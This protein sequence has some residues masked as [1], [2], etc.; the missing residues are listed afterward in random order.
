MSSESILIV[1]D[2]GLIALHLAEFLEQAGYH[3]AGTPF[4]GE[5]CVQMVRHSPPDLI[6][7]DIALAGPM[8]GVEAARQIRHRYDIPVIFLSAYSDQS[9]IDEA[10]AVSPYG[11]LTKPVMDD[12]LISTIEDALAQWHR[13]SQ[14]RTPDADGT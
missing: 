10:D 11:F 5:A 9:R 8:D 1:E 12:Q 7:M 13:H 4:S 6:L 14:D 2:E 3:I